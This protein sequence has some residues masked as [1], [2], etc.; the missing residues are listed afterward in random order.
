MRPKCEGKIKMLSEIKK[1]TEGKG[2]WPGERE[3]LILAAE[4]IFFGSH[5]RFSIICE[6]RKEPV[7]VVA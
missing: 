6:A 1:R 5:R 4:P 3:T 7:V 2:K